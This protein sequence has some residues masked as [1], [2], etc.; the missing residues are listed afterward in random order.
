[1]PKQWT[2]I[3]DIDTHKV[4]QVMRLEDCDWPI[5]VFVKVTYT[6]EYDREWAEKGKY[7]VQIEAV[8]PEAPEAEAIMRCINSIGSTLPEWNQADEV[9][10]ARA[11]ADYGIYAMLWQDQGNNLRKL[12]K[13][14]RNELASIPIFIGFRLD[15]ALNAIG[16]TGWDS[17]KGDIG[18]KRSASPA[19]E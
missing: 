10:R 16:N 6:E 3:E 1:M 7:H 15:R 8:A 11:L 18:F 17:L 5:L 9:W 12:L 4:W 2:V 13:A 14:A 19:A